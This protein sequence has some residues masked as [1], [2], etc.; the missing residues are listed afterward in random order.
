LKKNCGGQDT[1]IHN[2]EVMTGHPMEACIL[3]F[4]NKYTPIT[5]LSF[6][7][8]TESSDFTKC[9][10]SRPSLCNIHLPRTCKKLGKAPKER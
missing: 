6:L 1:D 7:S 10:Q 3:Y 5:S 8:Y 2:D 4:E 9:Q